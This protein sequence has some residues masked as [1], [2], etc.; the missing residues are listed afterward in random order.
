MEVVLKTTYDETISNL[1]PAFLLREE[2]IRQHFGEKRIR[3]VEFFGK[4][5]DWHMQWTREARMLYHVNVNRF[6]WLARLRA[7]W[8][9]WSA[10]LG[11]PEQIPGGVK[12][13]C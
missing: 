1:S 8:R 6:P 5:M 9:S 11:T 13:S 2:E 12:R 4:V 7:R 10:R 3:R